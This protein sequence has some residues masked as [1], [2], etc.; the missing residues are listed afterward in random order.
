MG[1][2]NMCLFAGDGVRSSMRKSGVLTSF[3]FMFHAA[4]KVGNSNCTDLF[5]FQLGLN[6]D[7]FKKFKDN[8]AAS[9]LVSTVSSSENAAPAAAQPPVSSSRSACFKNVRP[10]IVCSRAC[11]STRH[12]RCHW[13]AIRAEAEMAT[14]LVQVNLLGH[15][16]TQKKYENQGRTGRL[17]RRPLSIAQVVSTLP[18]PSLL[19]RRRRVCMR[20]RCWSGTSCLRVFRS[21]F[22]RT[23]L[24]LFLLESILIFCFQVVL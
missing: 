3:G 21:I 17:L 19:S 9:A 4:K 24:R 18:R 11:S 22:V 7:I 10:E 23:F 5:C 8:E 6:E 14:F 1:M 15:D 20:W 2:V 13:V 16:G 12:G